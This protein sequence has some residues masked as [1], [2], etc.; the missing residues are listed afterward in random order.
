[1]DQAVA[2]RVARQAE[3]GEDRAG[4]LAELGRRLEREQLADG[5][6]V[7]VAVAAVEPPGGSVLPDE[8][9]R[10]SQPCKIGIEQWTSQPWSSPRSSSG[11]PPRPAPPTARS[12]RGR[13][14]RRLSRT[15]WRGGRR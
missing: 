6:A 9:E 14:C 13:W 7:G 15:R 12:S 11:S 8:L 5:E 1:M 4:R 3:E 2:D 10:G